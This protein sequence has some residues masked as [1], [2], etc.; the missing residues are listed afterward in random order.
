MPQ[1]FSGSCVCQSL[2]Y[3]LSLDSPDDARTSLCHCHSCRRAFGTNFG[4]TMKVPL[5]SFDY[6][7]GT[8]TKFRQD[9]GVVREFCKEC[10]AYICE[11]GEQAVDKFRYIMWGT[12]DEADQFL[13]KGEFFCRDRVKWMP[14]IPGIFHK[15]EVH[16]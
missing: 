2:Q 7:K 14:E 11:Y 6:T 3:N 8:P 15:R 12:V 10:A 16:T 5:E 13:P 9:N 1:T 4:L